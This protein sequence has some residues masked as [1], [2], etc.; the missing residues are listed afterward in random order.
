MA[1]SLETSL[2]A[3]LFS[4]SLGGCV[5]GNTNPVTDSRFAFCACS[6]I[7]RF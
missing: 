6:K 5:S 4:I 2:W 1:V 3:A 7:R